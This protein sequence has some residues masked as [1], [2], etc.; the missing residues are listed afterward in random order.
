MYM[1]FGNT[2]TGAWTTY[3]NKGS[4]LAKKAANQAVTKSMTYEDLY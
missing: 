3:R 4:K 2:M 1:I